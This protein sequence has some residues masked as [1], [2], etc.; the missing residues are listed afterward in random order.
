LIEIAYDHG[1]NV[2]IVQKRQRPISWFLAISQNKP[3]AITTAIKPFDLIKKGLCCNAF[4]PSTL[5]AR[6]EKVLMKCVCCDKHKNVTG[7]LMML[8]KFFHDTTN[9]HSRQSM[10]EIVVANTLNQLTK[11]YY[12][13]PLECYLPIC[14]N[15]MKSIHATTD[16]GHQ[17]IYHFVDYF[18][19]S[20]CSFVDGVLEKVVDG[21]FDLDDLEMYLKIVIVQVIYALVCSKQI[22]GFVHRDLHSENI[23][24]QNFKDTDETTMTFVFSRDLTVQYRDYNMFLVKIIDFDESY[25]DLDHHFFVGAEDHEK[26]LFLESYSKEFGYVNDFVK[27]SAALNLCLTTFISDDFL[28]GL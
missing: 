28:M 14:C 17:N 12:Y 20:L 13:G 1:L 11:R 4:T 2:D 24:I 8:S 9:L 10:R 16:F 23:M 7:G 21:Y 22:C 19:E 18:E 26:D 15:F 3:W 6:I 25:I 5:G 27:F